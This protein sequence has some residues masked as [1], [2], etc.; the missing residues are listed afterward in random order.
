MAQT[1][2]VRASL[3]KQSTPSN[4]RPSD[5]N[6]STIKTKNLPP[7]IMNQLIKNLTKPFGKVTKRMHY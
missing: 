7:S 6:N 3:L 1:S 5:I 4:K 2:D